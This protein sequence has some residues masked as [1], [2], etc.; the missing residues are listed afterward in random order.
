M[1]KK[2]KIKKTIFFWLKIFSS[3]R[4]VSSPVEENVFKRASLSIIGKNL[5][6]IVIVFSLSLLLSVL[7]MLLPLLF[8][9]KKKKF[10]K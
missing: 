1:C 2:I 5:I 4:D 3:G 7:I 9:I 10:S 6:N 8:F